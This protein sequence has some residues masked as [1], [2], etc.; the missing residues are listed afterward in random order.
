MKN[1]SYD[2]IVVG[3]GVAGC[4]AALA[5]ARR[6]LKTALIEKTVTMGGLATNGLVLVYLALCDGLGH[7]VSF[8]ITEELLKAANIYGPFDPKDWKNGVQRYEAFFSPAS[9]ILA[10]DEM[11]MKEGIDMWF[12]TILVDAEKDADNKIRSIEVFNKSG[13]IKLEAKCFIDA[14]GDADLAHI[15]GN[16]CLTSTN[17]LVAWVIEHRDDIDADG[18]VFKFNDSA[19]IKIFANPLSNVDTESGISGKIV[20]D[21][22]IRSRQKYLD[23]LKEEY[24]SGRSD[25]KSRYPISLPT[26]PTMRKTRCIKARQPLTPE[27][28]WQ[29]VEDSVGIAADWRK[30]DSVWELPYGMLLPDNIEGMLAVGRAAGTIGDAWE[31]SRVI[32]V[33]AVTGEAAGVA[34]AIAVKNGIMPSQVEYSELVEEL[35]KGRF[36]PLKIKAL[37]LEKHV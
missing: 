15:A 8:G 6:G 27:M 31:V 11:L 20:S 22:V 5:A 17:A 12:D 9:L 7:Q 34:A 4:A 19:A 35:Q 10:L 36:F 16:E 13:K 14:T 2:L 28:E 3:G 21:F 29:S 30:K 37:G 18:K 25:R 1:K 32:P 23:Y 24:A 26:M 33:A